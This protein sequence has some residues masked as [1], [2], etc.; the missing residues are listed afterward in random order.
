MFFVKG[1]ADDVPM[2]EIFIGI[3]P[4]WAAM[5]VC[6]VMLVVFPEIALF[7]PNSMIQ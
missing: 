5:L 6:L 7:L 3:L 2:K 4:F 1:I